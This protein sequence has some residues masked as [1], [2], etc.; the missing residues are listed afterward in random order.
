M[1]VYQRNMVNI[2][3]KLYQ[4][5]FIYTL[6]GPAG[7][8]LCGKYT[9]TLNLTSLLLPLLSKNKKSTQSVVA[10]RDMGSLADRALGPFVC[11]YMCVCVFEVA[12]VR[13]SP[14]GS[15]PLAQPLHS[16]LECS[17]CEGGGCTAASEWSAASFCPS[18]SATP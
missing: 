9:L 15:P 10:G 2:V 4:T 12:C 7:C 6:Q 17:A 13:K 14:F 3:I 11:I 1:N 16:T 5:Y 8:F 18:P